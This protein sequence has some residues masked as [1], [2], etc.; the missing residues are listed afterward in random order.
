MEAGAPARSKLETASIAVLID[1][2][3]ALRG[4]GI[5]S[6][7][8]RLTAAL[9][10]V[11]PPVD[12]RQWKGSGEWGRAAVL[13]TL[14]RSGPFDVSPVLDPR[15]WGCDVVHL[16][17]NLGPLRPGRRSVVT[18]HD[19]MHRQ[20]A[21][22][23]DRLSGTLLE[24]CLTRASHVVAISERTKA[25]VEEALPTLIGRVEVIPH[26]LR[27]R[28]WP[29][30][31]RGH[32]LAFGGA[33]DPRKRVDLMVAA[34]REYRAAA[35]DPLPLVVLARAGLTADQHRHLTALGAKI[36]PTATA[37]E[38]DE[39]MAGA[40]AVLYTTTTEGF[41]LPILEAAEVG[42]RVVMDASAEVATE[43]V[44][45]HCLLVDGPTPR[46]W[47]DRLEQAVA[48]GPVADALDLPGWD[49]V[50]GRY[51]EIYRELA[52]R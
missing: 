15:T 46:H 11:H 22:R 43:V 25:Q 37:G 24:A 21:R 6:F 19:L 9:A 40:A 13:S 18:V 34:Y 45:R 8:D 50:A 14:A 39:L 42:T 16:A 48:E 23:R 4:L 36:V 28:P 10:D 41:G 31:P 1:A 44:G 29:V 35:P 12:A 27:R 7:L 33:G 49:S 3:L 32:V 20:R 30:A 17:S 5:A 26:G 38:V 2:R 51:A 47:A 52:R